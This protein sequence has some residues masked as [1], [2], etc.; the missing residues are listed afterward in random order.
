MIGR[1]VRTLALLVATAGCCDSALAQRVT[2][3]TVSAFSY[4]LDRS[5]EYN[6]RN[7]GAGVEKFVSDNVAVIGG[8]YRN[9]RPDG[10]GT[11]MYGGLTYTP[12]SYGPIRAGLVLGGVT[13][14]QAARVLPSAGA[15]ITLGDRTSGLNIHV[16][17]SA[18][19]RT[20]FST[21]GVQLK[22]AF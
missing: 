13:G 14:Y 12:I 11:S 7:A 3:L 5:R 15:L 18:S 9:S 10:E 1:G 17:P 22:Q 16:L 6:E 4:H 20:M 2:F 19:N 21:I 8:F